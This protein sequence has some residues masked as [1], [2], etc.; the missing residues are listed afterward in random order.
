MHLLQFSTHDIETYC[1]PNT[2][3]SEDVN[4]NQTERPMLSYND[5]LKMP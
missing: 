4:Y 2:N 5:A 3:G 1:K